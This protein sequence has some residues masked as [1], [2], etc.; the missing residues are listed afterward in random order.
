[1]VEAGRPL[2]VH[3]DELDTG[4][5]ASFGGPKAATMA[6][7][8]GRTAAARGRAATGDAGPSNAAPGATGR[9]GSARRASRRFEPVLGEDLA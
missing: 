6:L 2:G 9:W 7:A 4:Q 3:V 8:T 1:M 5:L